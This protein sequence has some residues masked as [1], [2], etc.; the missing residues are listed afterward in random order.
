MEKHKITT[1]EAVSEIKRRLMDYFSFREDMTVKPCPDTEAE[2]I[3]GHKYE[4]P[5]ER[6]L[7]YAEIC[8]HLISAYD[9]VS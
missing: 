2:Y 4:S 1:E 8:N 5:E 7:V 9:I 6:K 3:A